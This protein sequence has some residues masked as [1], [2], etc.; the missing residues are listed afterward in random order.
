L[1]SLPSKRPEQLTGKL[2]LAHILTIQENFK[3]FIKLL[4]FIVQGINIFI[5]P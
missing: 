2:E 5:K 4:H 1:V 3:R